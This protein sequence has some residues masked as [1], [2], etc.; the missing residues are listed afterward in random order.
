[1]KHNK[2][3]PRIAALGG[4]T[5]LSTLLRGLKRFSPNLTAIVTVTDDGGSSGTLRREL[6]VLPPGDIRNCLV[7]LSEEESLMAQLFQYRFP[8]AGSL[9]GHSFGNL[10]LAAMSELSGGFDLGITRVSE[11]LAI[12]GK[13]LPV[14]LRS[15]TLEAVL[16][17]GK[18][19]HGESKIA[20]SKSRIEQLRI[21]PSPPPAGPKVIEAILSA[22][23]IIIGPGSLYT[24]IIANLLVDGIS[25]AL[26]SVNVPKIY[27]CNIMTQPGESS[28]YKLS[29]HIN[30]IEKHAG[31]GLFNYVIVNQGNIPEDLYKKYAEENSYPV[32]I[33]IKEIPGIKIIKTNLVSHL[34]YARHDSDKLAK[35]INKILQL[36]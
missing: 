16:S 9:S 18:I 21:H 31:K 17:D 6:G 19:I 25:Q 11:V 32:E 23:F 26:H 7:A 10:F 13:V 4:G 27:I 29:D 28:G 2:L 12:C 15:V 1:M 24:S 30:A 35:V 8:A 20:H 22:D 36:Q 33:D 34:E 3:S 14:T 5:G